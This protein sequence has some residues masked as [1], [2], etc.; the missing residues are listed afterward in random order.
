[1]FDPFR[2]ARRFDPARP[3]PGRP[4][5]PAPAHPRQRRRLDPGRPD[6]PPRG[7]GVSG[8]RGLRPRFSALGRRGD[9]VG[10]GARDPGDPGGGGDHPL[11][12]PAVAPAGL[13][14]R[15]GAA[16]PGRGRVPGA[17]DRAGRAAP[18]RGGRRAAADRALRPGVALPERGA[19]RAPDVAVPRPFGGDC[20]Q[21]RRE[22]EAGRRP[23]DGTGRHLHHRSAAGAGRHRGAR[24]GRNLRDGPPGPRRL[25]RGDDRRRPGADPAHDPARRPGSPLSLLHRRPNRRIPRDGNPPRPADRLRLRLPRP[26]RARR[27]APLAGRLVRRTAATA[28]GD[29]RTGAGRRAGLGAGD[30]PPGRRPDARPAARRRRRGRHRPRQRPDRTGRGTVDGGG[31]GAERGRHAV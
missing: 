4:G 5:R 30:G 1:G 10:G 24:G 28:R 18:K 19:G 11:G 8:G 17:A 31:G 9:P 23:G 15:A 29:G 27:P 13:R 20:R 7:A 25:G 16:G 22:P 26:R 12:G 3:R 14:H 21:A 6:Q 2:R